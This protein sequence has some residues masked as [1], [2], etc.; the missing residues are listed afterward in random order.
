MYTNKSQTP[1]RRELH[2]RQM[3]PNVISILSD[4][5][6]IAQTMPQSV[7]NIPTIAQEYIPNTMNSTAMTFNQRISLSSNQETQEATQEIQRKTQ[8]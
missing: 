4:N 8:K 2:T 6:Y 1:E 5:S 7:A 3:E